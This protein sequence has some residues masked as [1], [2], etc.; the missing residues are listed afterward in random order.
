MQAACKCTVQAACKC[1]VQ[2]AYKCT[3]Q[4]ACKCS[5]QGFMVQVTA[6]WS[7]TIWKKQLSNFIIWSKS[8]CFLEDFKLAGGAKSFKNVQKQCYVPY[9]FQYCTVLTPSSQ[10]Q[11]LN[12]PFLWLKRTWRISHS[13]FHYLKSRKITLILFLKHIYNC[14]P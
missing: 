8:S 13:G 5:R 4:A 3:V 14:K 10:N 12:I 6:T 9:L 2:A 1:T 11:Y 7:W